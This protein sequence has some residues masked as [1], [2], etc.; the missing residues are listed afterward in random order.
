M[1]DSFHS[2]S[3]AI[4]QRLFFE[5][6]QDTQ[7]PSPT[8]QLV[9]GKPPRVVKDVN[10]FQLLAGQF[11]TMPRCEF[12]IVFVD[13]QVLLV[14]MEVEHSQR[15]G[16]QVVQAAGSPAASRDACPADNNRAM[17]VPMIAI[18]TKSSTREK[19]SRAYAQRRGPHG[20]NTIEFRSDSDVHHVARLTAA[21]DAVIAQLAEHNHNRP[22]ASISVCAR[23]VG[24][25]TI[26][27][28]SISLPGGVFP[29]DAE[30]HYL[31]PAIAI[32]VDRYRDGRPR[33]G[34]SHALRSR[35]PQIH[36]MWHSDH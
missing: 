13:R 36:E 31:H 23:L 2:D 5:L 11:V 30:I 14:V 15:Q 18:T 20:W 12:G 33:S 8:I 32:I 6:R 27:A 21:M 9:D 17:S 19:P 1:P 26:S 10:V 4:V 22:T 24:S 25:G 34:G 35:P 16:L 7:N 29:P 3:Q 28:G